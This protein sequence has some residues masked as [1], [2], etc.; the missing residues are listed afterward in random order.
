MKSK[1]P[2][3]GWRNRS[4]R[5]LEA[6]LKNGCLTNDAHDARRCSGPWATA[7]RG[8][9]SPTRNVFAGLPRVATVIAN[10]PSSA[11]RTG[12]AWS[13]WE[14]C[15]RRQLARAI[16]GARG[17]A[18]EGTVH[19]DTRLGRWARRRRACAKHRTTRQASTVD[20]SV[21]I[22]AGQ[23]AVQGRE[24]NLGT[25]LFHAGLALG[26]SRRDEAGSISMRAG[27]RELAI[28]VGSPTSTV[29]SKPPTR[30]SSGSR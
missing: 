22:G 12:W 7:L 20:L 18:G 15:L 11:F 14:S 16:G 28:G 17:E 1:H 23:G 30:P 8:L 9:F 6:Y 21:E 29:K 13:R 3:R 2:R 25:A 10:V 4:G 26:L 19:V 27:D 24:R 5:C